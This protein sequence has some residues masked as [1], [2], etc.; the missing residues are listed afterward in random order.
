MFEG[1]IVE[2][3][4]RWQGMGLYTLRVPELD[5]WIFCALHDARMGPPTGGT[6]LKVYPRAEE[7]LV[8][9]LRLSQ[10]MTQKW[11]ALGLPFG[12]GK[13][14]LCLSRA[15]ADQD[16]RELLFGRFAGVLR[17]LGD[18]FGTGQDLGTTPGDMRRLARLCSSIHGID[19]GTGEVEDP[20]PYTALGVH[21][22]MKSALGHRFGSPDL[23][24]R[25]VLI[26][27]LGG[28]G[29][30]LARRLVEEG[31]RL[32]L[33]DLDEGRARELASEL[34]AQVLDRGSHLSLECDVYSP[35]AVGATLSEANVGQLGCTIVCGAANNQ[36]GSR[37][38]AQ[39]LHA[40]GVLYAPDFI[41]NAGGAA[42]CSGLGTAVETEVLMG[43]VL[44]IG[45]TLTEVLEEA[46]AQ[47]ESPQLAAERRVDR[48]LAERG[49]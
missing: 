22:A 9:A 30:P 43:R 37:D 1:R 27:G 31:A 48:V 14:V 35:C 4:D 45:R 21:L 24:G 15:L 25:T 16:E 2:E 42:Y 7:G 32:K 49:G 3:I 33:V 10:G 41:V 38:D 47:D 6:R 8:D 39:R 36:L 12:G 29:A 46:R 17:T 18:R 23:E 13:A 40:R 28:V 34:G 19:A 26:E 5:A 11:A 44:R 20:G